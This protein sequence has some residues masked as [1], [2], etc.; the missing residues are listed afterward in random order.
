MRQH[1]STGLLVIVLSFSAGAAAAADQEPRTI[2]LTGQGEA[3]AAPDRAILSAGVVTQAPSAA[4][5]LAANR[6]AM[7]RV[8]TTLK[9]LGIPDRAMQ[10]SEFTVSPQYQNDRNGNSQRIVGYQVTNTVSVTLD[11]LLKLGPAIDV[12]VGSGA[13]TM[14][15]IGFSIRDP[16]PLEAEAR[17]AAMHDAMEKAQVYAKAAG[18]QLG[19]ILAISEG[20]A[21]PRPMMR[22]AM[23][24][25]PMDSTPIATGEESISANVSVTFEIH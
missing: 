11:D 9:Q 23:A 10:T 16:K 6:N 18:V 8:F 15:G 25:A 17:T 22:M 12:L 4:A 13:N 7:N 2:T 3:K 14:G 24:N 19:A 21:A 1:I 20:G 5:A